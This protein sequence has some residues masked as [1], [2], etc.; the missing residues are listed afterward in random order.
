MVQKKVLTREKENRAAELVKQHPIWTRKRVQSQLRK[1]FGSGLRYEYFGELRG[2][3]LSAGAIGEHRRRKLMKLG[4]LPSEAKA[5]SGVALSSPLMQRYIRERQVA[6]KVAKEVGMPR[7]AFSS[8]IRYQYKM[9]GFYKKGKLQ[10]LE[11]LVTWTKEKYGMREAAVV[12]RL[13]VG[14]LREWIPSE[15]RRTYNRWLN[16]GFLP[17]EAVDFLKAKNWLKLP[18][19]SPGRMARRQRRQW[20]RELKR[21]GWTNKQIIAELRQFYR[22]DPTRSP[23]DFIRRYKPKVKKDFVVYARAARERADEA[24]EKVGGFYRRAL[25]RRG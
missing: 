21:R 22:R 25:A 14:A 12:G 24:E 5:L 23:W 11:R 7:K 3:I 20:V 9:E 16:D 4:F 6:I 1:E 8:Q 18:M 2:E 17:E 10:P 19:T 13:G 15:K